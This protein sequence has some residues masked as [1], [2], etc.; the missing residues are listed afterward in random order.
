MPV[1]DMVSRANLGPGHIKMS[2]KLDEM[3][4]VIERLVDILDSE[5]V[6]VVMGDH[7]M[8]SKG[9][10]GGESIN[11][12]SAGLFIYSAQQLIPN[13]HPVPPSQE[14]LKFQTESF[15]RDYQTWFVMSPERT[16]AQIDLVPTLALLLGIPI[17]FGNLGMVIPEVFSVAANG[18]NA[19]ENMYEA[20]AENAR[21]MFEYLQAY[22]VAQPDAKHA[23]GDK[24]ELYLS[25]K[26]QASAISS[27]AD[28]LRISGLHVQFMRQ[29][30]AAARE[31][32]ARFDVALIVMGCILILAG[33]L[34]SILAVAE[35]NSSVYIVRVLIP[36]IAGGLFGF[37]CPILLYLTRLDGV[38]SSTL[39]PIHEIIFFSTVSVT[40]FAICTIS[41]N[42]RSAIVA[43]RSYSLDPSMLVGMAVLVMTSLLTFSDSF[44]IFHDHISLY[45]LQTLV[46]MLLI[47]APF[48]SQTAELAAVM[49]LIRIVS[50]STICREDQGPYCYVTFYQSSSSSISSVYSPMLLFAAGLLVVAYQ[51]FNDTRGKV[52]GRNVFMAMMVAAHCVYWTLDTLESHQHFKQ[53]LLH[54]PYVARCYFILLA[55]GAALSRSGFSDLVSLEQCTLLLLIMAQKPIGAACLFL[56]FLLLTLLSKNRQFKTV[57]P[58]YQNMIWLLVGNLGFYATGHQNELSSI[59]YDMG[60]IGLDGVNWVISPL[61]VAINTYG[62]YLLANV[63]ARSRMDVE[64]RQHVWGVLGRNCVVAM[65]VFAAGWFRRHSQQTRVWGPRFVFGIVG[66]CI[67]QVASM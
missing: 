33:I 15:S 49:A 30:L 23:F 65:D 17:P 50:L 14:L 18:K 13:A 4:T 48:G 8:D 29:S 52:R 60:F 5:T 55:A 9:D 31:I 63:F 22:S 36:A 19:S 2:Q 3:N 1:I 44:L 47:R 7:G 37:S 20:V 12:L 53:S 58:A 24:E 34:I 40:Y 56:S 28:R 38:A 25:A 39:R 61:L 21:Q 43:Q 45:F 6:M 64:G 42:I 41:W 57:H 32:W 46:L 35:Q 51:I 10:H 27:D 16:V 54:K 66:Y 67:Q 59:Q 26:G 11:E 62:G